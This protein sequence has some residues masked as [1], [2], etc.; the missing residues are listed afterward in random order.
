MDDAVW[1]TGGREFEI[2]PLRPLNQAL[3]LIFHPSPFCK[4]G[5]KPMR[6]FSLSRYR[7]RT[8]CPA[9]GRSEPWIRFKARWLLG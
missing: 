3:T 1:G 2:A 5:I 8:E 9:M 6:R 7:Q 4:R